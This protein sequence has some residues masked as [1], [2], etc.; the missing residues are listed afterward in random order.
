MFKGI[1]TLEARDAGKPILT[2]IEMNSD[3]QPFIPPPRLLAQHIEEKTK[4]KERTK[5]KRK[6]YR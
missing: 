5:T 3:A 4:T 2:R 6:L 1:G